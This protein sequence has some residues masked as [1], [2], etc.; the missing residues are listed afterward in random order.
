MKLY[1]KGMP[2]SVQVNRWTGWRLYP[3]LRWLGKHPHIV[4][5]IV[6]ATLVLC[7]VIATATFL[8]R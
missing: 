5:I 6:A 1:I 3:L 2:L 8:G 7:M 4:Q